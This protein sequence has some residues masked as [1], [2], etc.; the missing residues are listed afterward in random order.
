MLAKRVMEKDQLLKAVKLL[1]NDLQKEKLNLP[2]VE[3]NINA[4]NKR[5]DTLKSDVHEIETAM[6]SVKKDIDTMK[7][8]YSKHSNLD[9][10][11]VT[12]LL[13]LTSQNDALER[14]VIKLQLQRHEL[15]ASL[16]TMERETTKRSRETTR[17]AEKLRDAENKLKIL[18]MTISERA[19]AEQ[20]IS[21]LS[22]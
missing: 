7:S 9:K 15:E 5:L 10:A 22:W 17:S 12:R 6:E 14:D 20:D 16:E 2:G 21:M 1:D 19:R 13:E 3:S 18:E 4:S 8:Q 11:H